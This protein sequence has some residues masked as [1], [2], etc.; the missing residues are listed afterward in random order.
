MY[1]FSPLNHLC[2]DMVYYM[3]ILYTWISTSVTLIYVSIFTKT[4]KRKFPFSW[5]LDLSDTLLIEEKQKEGEGKDTVNVN[6]K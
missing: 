1:F 4:V 2:L 3:L 6:L 5:V